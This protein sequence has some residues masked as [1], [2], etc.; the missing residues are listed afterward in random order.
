[1]N[2]IKALLVSWSIGA[3]LPYL[4]ELSLSIDKAVDYQLKCILPALIYMIM[5][6]Y[7]YHLFKH[8]LILK[9]KF[10]SYIIAAI[11]VCMIISSLFNYLFV[12]PDMYYLLLDARRGDGLS[13]KNI[14]RAVE[15]IAL[16]TVGKNG[17][18][19]IYN[20]LICSCR[21]FSVIIANNSTYK[22]GR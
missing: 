7:C 6:V 12:F 9:R 21:W 1:M 15:I 17:I 3:G 22:I 16:L 8:E 11:C 20:R 4:S 5:A 18:I 2:I 13:W 14:Y 10:G 19:Y